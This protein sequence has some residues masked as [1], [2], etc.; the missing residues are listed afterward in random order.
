MTTTPAGWLEPGRTIQE[1]L[2]T[3][4]GSRIEAET[5]ELLRV[6]FVTTALLLLEDHTEDEADRLALRHLGR[7]HQALTEHDMIVRQYADDDPANAAAIVLS[8]D[9]EEEEDLPTRL[10]P[11]HGGGQR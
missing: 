6:V 8:L 1:M 10:G 7:L 11:F 9:D 5:E 3:E 4:P 2:L